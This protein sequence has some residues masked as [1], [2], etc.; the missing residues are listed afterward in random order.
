MI[1]QF[2]TAALDYFQNPSPDGMAYQTVKFSIPFPQYFVPDKTAFH[3]LVVVFAL[4]SNSF[5]SIIRIAR[6]RFPDLLGILLFGY[7]QDVVRFLEN[8]PDFSEVKLK[9]LIQIS[10]ILKY[11]LG[12]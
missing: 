5:V 4:T 8:K 12:F 11:F 1:F 6:N 10:Q 9:R 7:S 3:P 2:V